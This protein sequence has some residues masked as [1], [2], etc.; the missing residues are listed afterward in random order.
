MTRK[1]NIS[2]TWQA[3]LPKQPQK[4]SPVLRKP[5]VEDVTDPKLE[6]NFDF[7]DSEVQS[8]EEMESDGEDITLK[9]IQSDAELLE[10]ASRLSGHVQDQEHTRHLGACR[11]PTD[12]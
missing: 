4:H 1:K 7:K 3:N 9:E 6:R 8:E 10:F 2:K 12:L 11:A 5:T